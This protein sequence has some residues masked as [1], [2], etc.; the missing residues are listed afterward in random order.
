MGE[1]YQAQDL[2]LGCD[3]ALK[4]LIDSNSLDDASLARFKREVL[5][6]KVSSRYVCQIYDFGRH[7]AGTSEIPYLTMEYLEGET[8]SERIRRV[9]PVSSEQALPLVLGMI[10][11][12]EAAHKAGIVHRD[13]KS[14]NVMLV[15]D[16]ADIIPKVT[17]FG[18]AKAFESGQ[19]SALTETGRPVGT[20]LYMAPERY[21]GQATEASDI[22]SL[23]IVIH[24]MLTGSSQVRDTS[25]ASTPSPDAMQEPWHRV[26]LKCVHPDPLQRFAR[27]E[28]I[29]ACL[30]GS[31]ERETRSLS[32]VPAKQGQSRIWIAVALG[33]LLAI[34]AVALWLSRPPAA[35]ERRIAIL[36]FMDLDRSE[37]NQAFCDGLT[38]VI[39]SKLTQLEAFQNSLLVLPTTEVRKEKITTAREAYRTLGADL[40]L[41]GT[42]QR[43]AGSIRII[44]NLIEADRQRQ[45]NSAIILISRRQNTLAQ[46]EVITKIARMLNVAPGPEA[47][48]LLARG[49]TDNPSAYDYY[50]Q[51]WG[52]LRRYGTMQDAE[53]AIHEFNRSLSID[54][55]FALA[56]TGLGEAYWRKY[57]LTKDKEWI[58][59][60][61]RQ[62]NRARQLNEQLAPLHTT[63]GLL[64]S[65]TGQYDRAEAEYR[66][67]LQ[68]DPGNHDAFSGLASAYRAA[69]RMND[70]ERVF[71]D[72]I[73]ARPGY[74]NGYARLGKFYAQVG[75]YADAVEPFRHAIE[76]TPDNPDGYSNLGGVYVYLGRFD[77]AEREFKKSLAL[78]P[79]ENAYSNLGALYLYERRYSEAVPLLEK[80]ATPECNNYI[81][82]GNLG[83]AYRWTSADK[84]RILY[85]YGNA[86][87]LARADL[88]VNPKNAEALSALATYLA[89]TGQYRQAVPVSDQAVALAPGAVEVLYDAA[90]TY[91]LSG[92]RKRALEALGR[93]LQAGYSPADIQKDADMDR[94]RS[95]PA[96]IALLRG[97]L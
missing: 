10:E 97:R 39:A 14:S 85:S 26:I 59:E 44:A 5:A 16:G 35:R 29:R 49:S 96:G 95:D 87:R 24:E 37:E 1:V 25:R 71:K 48:D 89:K 32:T 2:E 46:D 45:T 27:A 36:P 11:A 70:A 6:R 93:A 18:L 47:R 79:T 52:Y 63:L 19:E 72:A 88:D 64:F 73:R 84:N 41:T 81:L 66:R 74:W 8:L 68:I 15:R 62:C 92:M 30:L 9:G 86:I 20:P 60:A 83:D 4:T 58:Q 57:S 51:G 90:L 21:M 53:N 17:D 3:V 77:E 38:E 65:G 55:R 28:Q 54:P 94:I 33:L 82:W 31:E 42:V 40:V 7:K 50:L 67:A 22:Y 43:E 80:V 91:E 75:R 13:I 56:Y 12:L 61:W 78:R 23:G 69:G 76:L 34:L